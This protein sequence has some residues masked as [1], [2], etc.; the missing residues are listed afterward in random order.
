M[1]VAEFKQHILETVKVPIE[2][3]KIIFG[4]KALVDEKPMTEYST[5]FLNYSFN[6]RKYCSSDC[7]SSSIL[8]TITITTDPATN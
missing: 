6:I 7:K 3:Q 1:T 4:G 8:T 2:K 5:T